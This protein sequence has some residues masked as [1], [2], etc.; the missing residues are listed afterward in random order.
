MHYLQPTTYWEATSSSYSSPSVIVQESVLGDLSTHESLYLSPEYSPSQDYS[1]AHSHDLHDPHLYNNRARTPPPPFNYASSSL[2]SA[3]SISSASPPSSYLSTPSAAHP[4]ELL[5]S[6]PIT[7]PDHSHPIQPSDVESPLTPASGFQN[8]REQDS[9]ILAC[10]D[11]AVP[12][13]FVESSEDI[14]DNEPN[15][16]S[17]SPVPSTDTDSS[18]TPTSPPAVE[19]ASSDPADALSTQEQ[20]PS[21]H[22]RTPAEKRKAAVTKPRRKAKE[23]GPPPRLSANLPVTSE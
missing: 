15:P 6:A 22:Y 19:Q 9:T 16:S 17:G 4:P 14:T 2:H 3:L 12:V 21:R 23:E 7:N 13:P 11:M 20:A 5:N 18:P 10:T 8:D 1:P